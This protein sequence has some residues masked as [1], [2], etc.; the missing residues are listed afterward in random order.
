MAKSLL[1]KSQSGVFLMLYTLLF[2]F[3]V[4]PSHSRANGNG[5]TGNPMSGFG[6]TACTPQNVDAFAAKECKAEPPESNKIST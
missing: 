2:C 6:Q 5:Q 1:S 4:L 3:F